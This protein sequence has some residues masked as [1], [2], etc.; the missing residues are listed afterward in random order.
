MAALSQEGDRFKRAEMLIDIGTDALRLKFDELLPTTTLQETLQPMKSVMKRKASRP[1]VAILYPTNGTVLSMNM[2]LTLMAFVLRIT[3]KVAAPH[4]STFDDKPHEHEISDGADVARL[5]FFRNAL[6][7]AKVK[8]LN[9]QE[10][11]EISKTLKKVIKRLGK[12]RFDDRITHIMNGSLD[13]RANNITWHAQQTIYLLPQAVVKGVLQPATVLIIRQHEK[14]PFQWSIIGGT[15]ISVIHSREEL[16]Y[17]L[18]V[19][20]NMTV[21]YCSC[22]L[23]EHPFFKQILAEL[24]SY[25]RKQNHSP[26]YIKPVNATTPE[27][28][29]ASKSTLTSDLP[30]IYAQRRHVEHVCKDQTIREKKLLEQENSMSYSDDINFPDSQNS[31][32]KIDNFSGSN[33]ENNFDAQCQNVLPSKCQSNSKLSSNNKDLKSKQ[34]M[35]NGEID[36]SHCVE[37]GIAV[38]NTSDHLSNTVLP[39]ASQPVLIGNDNVVTP[40]VENR[41]HDEERNEYITYFTIL[42]VCIASIVYCFPRL[43]DYFKSKFIAV[44]LTILI[45]IFE[46]WFIDV[47]FEEE[48]CVVHTYGI[49]CR[50]QIL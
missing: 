11:N 19:L 36:L 10:F 39:N 3:E 6:V 42:S 1:H 21:R 4:S 31:S 37:L 12:S 20:Q 30:Y 13:Y 40:R 28:V 34:Y 24:I 33:I 23:N 48:E 26:N 8:E 2:D 41:E 50:H 7:H 18:G 32:T 44:I 15:V 35:E 25:Q 9:E 49:Y 47:F 22:V 27:D 17:Y 43:C 29:L 38:T 45:V 14:Q 5:K 46:V 16:I